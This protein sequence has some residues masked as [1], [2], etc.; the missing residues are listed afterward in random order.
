MS[1]DSSHNKDQ[2]EKRPTALIVPTKRNKKPRTNKL[3]SYSLLRNGSSSTSN[4]SP[5]CL[6]QDDAPT[7]SAT[8]APFRDDKSH[9]GINKIYQ[10]DDD[11][12]V[13]F[14]NE[15]NP[16]LNTAESTATNNKNPHSDDSGCESESDTNI[17]DLTDPAH[18]TSA[19]HIP[20]SAASLSPQ[21]FDEAT[22][23]PILD[24][25]YSFSPDLTPEGMSN[26][27]G[28]VLSHAP[29]APSLPLDVTPNAANKSKKT[30]HQ[31]RKG[32]KIAT[33]TPEADQQLHARPIN[34]ISR[35][36]PDYESLTLVEL[37]NAVK[38]YG[39]KVKDRQAMIDILKSVYSS[40]NTNSPTLS[41]PP[42]STSSSSLSS[43][44]EPLTDNDALTV[45][46]LE[47]QR[48][49]N[50]VKNDIQLWER[51]LRYEN[52]DIKTCS[53][54]LSSKEK[55]AYHEYLDEN[56]LVYKPSKIKK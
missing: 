47:K 13:I 22:P 48:F 2:Y 38:K 36:E 50:R 56:A 52:V 45:K 42:P 8:V 12:E 37:R 24:F 5:I 17:I 15:S 27:Q 46:R 9:Y 21:P 32:N 20:N 34:T 51:I 53:E 41:I 33:I 40:I 25:S 1:T 31:K 44:N 54:G 26:K 18:L 23:S 29:H 11:D 39:F 28:A 19:V 14:M 49:A 30:G 4:H 6:D 3:H 16:W 35:Q 10:H 55:S 43:P 7:N